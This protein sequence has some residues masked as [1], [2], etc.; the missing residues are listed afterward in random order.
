V[1]SEASL[2]AFT[3]RTPNVRSRVAYCRVS[4]AAQKPD[5]Q[6]PGARGGRLLCAGGVANVEYVE[7]VGEGLNVKRKKFVAL[8][9][10][11]EAGQV[12]RLIIAHKDRLVRF[13]F[14]WFDQDLYNRALRF[15]SALWPAQSLQE[16][17]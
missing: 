11:I 10:R 16:A 9:D 5:L 7:E 4:S 1:Y 6:K 15:Y 8:M 17:Q 12:S 2:E 14:S 13:G 3:R